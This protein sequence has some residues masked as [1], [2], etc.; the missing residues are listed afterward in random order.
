METQDRI[1]N[2]T[3]FSAIVSCFGLSIVYVA[4]LYV[5]DSSYNRNHPS[6]I[7]K[8]FLSVFIVAVISPTTFYFGLDKNLLQKTTIWELSGLRLPGIVQATVIPLLLTMVLFLGP[9]TMQGLS[10]LLRLYAE[11]SFWICRI[12]TLTLWRNLVIGPLSEEWTFRACM[13]PVLLQCFEPTTA[14]FTCSLFFGIAHFH[15]ILENMKMG[16]KFTHALILSAVQFAY[17]T[18]FGAYAAFLFVKTGHIMAPFAAHSFCNHMGLPNFPEV[19]GYKSPMK[20]F[21]ILSLFV[22]GLICWCLL[23]TPMTNPSIW[24]KQD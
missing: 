14:I 20:R 18:I 9:L 1:T 10:G 21:V 24:K 13:L 6:I 8:R 16:M 11:P 7:R 19:M 17:T 5:W 12:R 15:H 23:L 4:S 22:I 3:C 2:E